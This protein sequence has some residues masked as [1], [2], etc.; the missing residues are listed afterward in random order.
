[1]G[2]DDGGERDRRPRR[3]REILPR[4]RAA[5]SEAA[6]EGRSEG[7]ARTALLDRSPQPPMFAPSSILASISS[8]SWVYCEVRRARCCLSTDRTHPFRFDADS[9]AILLPRQ[10]GLGLGLGHGRD[11]VAREVQTGLLRC[12]RSSVEHAAAHRIRFGQARGPLFVHPTRAPGDEYGIS[13][14]FW[15]SIYPQDD[16]RYVD[17][18]LQSVMGLFPGM[19][20]VNRIYFMGFSSGGLFSYPLAIML[21]HRCELAQS[22]SSHVTR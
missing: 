2:S 3:H 15:Q 13:G 4:P 1:M 19:I 18:V 5:Q 17:T 16:V 9:A 11:T 12:V 8:H 14:C 22:T 6:H 21:S 7:M 20:D 10:A